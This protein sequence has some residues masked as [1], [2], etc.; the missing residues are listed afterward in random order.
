MNFLWVAGLQ[1]G[2][3]QA[4]QDAGE[5]ERRRRDDGSCSD[6]PA[7]SGGAPRGAGDG[8]VLLGLGGFTKGVGHGA[9]SVL[10]G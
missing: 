10:L 2:E 9:L 4:G 5:D 1:E 6:L 3:S 7:G 8:P